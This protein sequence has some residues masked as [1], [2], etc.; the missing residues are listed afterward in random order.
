MLFQGLQD[1]RWAATDA[2]LKKAYKKLV[3]KYH[4]DKLSESDDKDKTE[5]TFRAIQKAYDVLMDP[6]KRRDYDSQDAPKDEPYPS[7]QDVQQASEEEFY[8]LCGDIFRRQAKWSKDSD[9]P[10]IG[11]SKTPVKKVKSFYKWWLQSFD[12]WRTWKHEDEYEVAEAENRAERR[13]ME[14]QNEKLQRSFKQ[15]EKS[16]LV[17][18][19]NLVQK[20]DPRLKR[21]KEEAQKKKEE[22]VKAKQEELEKK[23]LEEEELQQ[24]KERLVEEKEKAEAAER[25]QAKKEREREKRRRKDAL[26]KLRN[27]CQPFYEEGD[28]VCNAVNTEILISNLSVEEIKSVCHGLKENGKEGIKTHYEKALEDIERKK[29]EGRK[30]SQ[31]TGSNSSSNNSN[32]DNNNNEEDA[33]ESSW[34]IDELKQ[35]A[36]AT[37]KFP[38]GYQNRWEHIMSE[39]EHFGIKK[40]LEDVQKTAVE[41]KKGVQASKVVDEAEL[42]RSMKEKVDKNKLDHGP[43]VNYEQQIALEQLQDWSPAQL[44]QLQEGLA[45]VPARETT[46]NRWE[47]IAQKY[48]TSKSPQQCLAKY[49]QLVAA[50]K[51]KKSEATDKGS[52]EWT[53]EQQK[54]LEKGLKTVP[55]SD[56]ERWDKIA[57]FVNGKD[58]AQVIARYK[59]LVER[60]KKAKK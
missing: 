54:Q 49:K 31:Q 22:K 50:A 26:K 46:E 38:G 24:E 1:L 12:S 43:S 60:L 8:K 7:E 59:E 5:E 44:K 47:V 35:L 18:F 15:K 2:E 21:V 28:S 36:M 33:N 16:D 56:S 20:Y 52:Q 40:S 27:L 29:M 37:N 4:P 48:V 58:K 9:V 13:W 10:S 42:K 17:D 34:T 53:A 55:A 41:L 30:K 11:D 6:D 51:A 23:R 45:A 32:N 3:L 25:E 14:R 39:L 57:A 19:V